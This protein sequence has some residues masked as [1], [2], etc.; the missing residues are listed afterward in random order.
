W[1]RS[2]GRDVGIDTARVAVAG[3]S[4]GGNLSAVVSQLAASS[5]APV[6]SCQVLIY[7]AVDFSL[8][9]DSHREL[10]DGHVMPRESIVWYM[11]HYLLRVEDMY[12]LSGSKLWGR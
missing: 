5:G 6:P 8:E 9:T 4:A 3:D 10:V 7:P 12:D 1:L 2:R 11:E